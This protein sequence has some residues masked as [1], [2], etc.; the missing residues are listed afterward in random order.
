MAICAKGGNN[1]MGDDSSGRELAR[2]SQDEQLRLF[3]GVVQSLMRDA[4]KVLA[5]LR[6]E[7]NGADAAEL[8]SLLDHYVSYTGRLCGEESCRSERPAI[9]S[10][11]VIQ[12]VAGP[13]TA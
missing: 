6:L 8:M 2:L 5:E 7:V 11:T 13:G 1:A 10:D 3:K 12:P 4:S 9:T